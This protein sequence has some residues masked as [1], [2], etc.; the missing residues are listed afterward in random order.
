M[1][2]RKMLPNAL[3]LFVREPNHSAFIVDQQHPRNFEMG[4]NP[5]RQTYTNHRERS[6]SDEEM[7]ERGYITGDN[8]TTLLSAALAERSVDITRHSRGK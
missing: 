6:A 4:S 8:G 1:L 3:P 5:L 2:L 7:L